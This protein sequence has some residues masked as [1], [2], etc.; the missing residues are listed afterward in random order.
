MSLSPDEKVMWDKWE[1][2]K[3]QHPDTVFSATIDDAESAK[4]VS[5]GVRSMSPEEFETRMTIKSSNKTRRRKPERHKR[6]ALASTYR[7]EKEDMRQMRKAIREAERRHRKMKNT[8][9][10]AA[11]VL[12]IS[13]KTLS[14]IAPI[15]SSTDTIIS[16]GASSLEKEE[17]ARAAAKKKWRYMLDEGRLSPEEFEQ[18]IDADVRFHNTG[19]R[20]KQKTR[21]KKQKT[22]RKKCTTCTRG[23]KNKRYYTRKMSNRK[24]RKR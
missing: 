16:S 19:G 8:L 1:E 15:E 4:A 20:R 13:Q 22:R 23:L 10:E 18:M 5:R 3:K 7:K 17:Q 21:R 11:K 12:D 24:Y 2:Y 9:G 6:N 14:R